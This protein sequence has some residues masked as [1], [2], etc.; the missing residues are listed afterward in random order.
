[1]LEVWLDVHPAVFIPVS[2]LLSLIT[3]LFLLS[4]ALLRFAS[5]AATCPTEQGLQAGGTTLSPSDQKAFI[6]AMSA[7]NEGD[8][9]KAETLLRALHVRYPEDFETN[10]ALG[11]L[12]ASQ[13]NPSEAVHRLADAVR[14][15]PDSAVAH[16][17]L[18]TADSDTYSLPKEQRESW[19]VPL[20]CNQEIRKRRKL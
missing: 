12:Y 3:T 8:S 6:A 9:A 7:M 13:S 4:T 16:A 10:E 11:L 2:L 20:N 14:E 19:N 17:N 15:C 18:G 1:M 5:L